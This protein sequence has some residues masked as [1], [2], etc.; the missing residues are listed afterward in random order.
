[1]NKP[2]PGKEL[3]DRIKKE[4]SLKREAEKAEDYASVILDGVEIIDAKAIPKHDAQKLNKF[5]IPE[6]KERLS[7]D[8][9]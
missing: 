8:K 9:I 6:P 2:S 5:G 3:I 4:D 7:W 1:L